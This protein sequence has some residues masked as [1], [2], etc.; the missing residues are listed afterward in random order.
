MASRSILINMV[1][2]RV[3]NHQRYSNGDSPISWP[4]AKSWS[5]AAMD[6]A[7]RNF[8]EKSVWSW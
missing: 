6:Y 1:R 5:S 7:Y 4:N 8:V 3:R 2:A